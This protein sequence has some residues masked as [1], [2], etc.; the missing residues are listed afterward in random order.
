MARK[1]FSL[2]SPLTISSSSGTS[3]IPQTPP[4]R[5]TSSTSCLALSPLQIP[6]PS[7]PPP[8]PPRPKTS[9]PNLRPIIILSPLAIPPRSYRLPSPAHSPKT[10]KR[11]FAEDVFAALPRHLDVESASSITSHGKQCSTCSSPSPI[12]RTHRLDH[13]S[14]A[15]DRSAI[16]SRTVQSELTSTVT[17]WPS[18]IIEHEGMIKHEDDPRCSPEIASVQQDVPTPWRSFLARN[19]R[20]LWMLATLFFVVL[21]A[22]AI[23]GGTIWRLT[24]RKRSH[25]L[26]H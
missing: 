8:R 11:S 7:S 1:S 14:F 9:L 20:P 15:D 17:R 23:A 24:L 13:V 26:P 18:A 12:K 19:R 2:T 21:A 6:P 22:A 10:R 5:L 25:T 3:S 4:K 16:T